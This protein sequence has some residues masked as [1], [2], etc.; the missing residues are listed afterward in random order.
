MVNK[1][2]LLSNAALP[3]WRPQAWARGGTCPPS[4]EML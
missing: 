1:L 3:S 4:L 2:F